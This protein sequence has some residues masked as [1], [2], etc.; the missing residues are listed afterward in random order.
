LS[1]VILLVRVLSCYLPSECEILD[2]NI[3]REH[4]VK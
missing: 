3:L 2:V 4:V 1:R